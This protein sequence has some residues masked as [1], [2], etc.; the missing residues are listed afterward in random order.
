VTQAVT[1]SPQELQRLLAEP[2]TAEQALDRYFVPT[3]SDSNPFRI[4]YQLR[5]NVVLAAPKGQP[6]LMGGFVIGLANGIARSARLRRYRENVREFPT[7]LRAVS[8]GDSWFQH[9]LIPDVID[10]LDVF[11]VLSLDAAGDE[12]LDMAEAD[13]FTPAL[14]REQAHVLLLSGGGN[15]L[16]G[17][18]FA[19][20][21]NKIPEAQQG[22]PALLLNTKLTERIDQ[23]LTTY[24]GIFRRVAQRDP[25]VRVVVHG[26][27]YA[28][29]APDG[30][31]LG[32]PMK[33]KGITAPHRRPLIRHLLDRFNDGL[34][35]VVQRHPN[36]RYVNARGAVADDEWADE[37]HPNGVGFKKVAD[38]F[39]AAI[40]G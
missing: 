33:S 10:H 6:E 7:R 36:A 32:K 39:V 20:Y 21:L 34:A 9:P 37:I 5:P 27:D 35:A 18:K 1:I 14:V 22:N 8:D 11:N 4:D 17:K 30:K 31:W 26:Y 24:E 25:R 16:M 2:A 23:L 13:E 3:P 15:D 19:S 28:I 29:P 12:L 40:S 38:R